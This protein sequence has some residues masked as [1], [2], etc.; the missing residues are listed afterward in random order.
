M[1]DDLC[2]GPFAEPLVEASILAGLVRHGASVFYEVN[3][4]LRPESFADADNQ[5]IYK[6]LAAALSSGQADSVDR[7]TLYVAAAS[8]GFADYLERPEIKR[9]IE[10]L[11]RIPVEAD[12][13]EKLCV[14]LKIIETSR[15][16]RARFRLADENL[17]RVT[18]DESIDE[19]F[20]LAEEP[21][22]SVML[23][24]AGGVKFARTRQ[25]AEGARERFRERIRNPVA[26]VGIP[27][28][29]SRFDRAHGGCRP[30]SVT[31]I[32]ARMKTGKTMFVNNVAINVA[33]QLGV[34]VLNIDTEMDIEQQMD[35][36]AACLSGL[37]TDDLERGSLNKEQQRRLGAAL[38]RL[39][40]M[41]YFYEEVRDLP[42]DAILS[43]IKRWV[44]KYVGFQP[45]GKANPC[46]VVFD[47]FKLMTEG[48]AQGRL[49]IHHKMGFQAQALKNLMAEL[50]TPC[51]CFAQANRDGID[52]TDE[53]I[54]RDADR[55]LD[56]VT[57]FWVFRRKPDAEIMPARKGELR[58]THEL[59]FCL[60]RFGKGLDRANYINIGTDYSRG[61]MA[62][63][64]TR[65]EL[66]QQQ[67]GLLKGVS[68]DAAPVAPAAESA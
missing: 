47:Y 17:S 52:F 9:Y 34:P 43:R 54:L 55:I 56:T 67:G 1:T 21:V 40:K 59:Y 51:V 66:F 45:N 39:E 63:G 37:W 10:S 53:R 50:G 62:E 19:L 38:D 31:L 23:E 8:L 22:Q 42:F 26:A 24:L 3:L 4:L 65:D 64:P 32:C 30:G 12:S 44:H 36:A 20:R 41:P 27:T 60:S 7:P 6:C 28:G 46:L 11:Y 29:F 57:S 48:E 35:R 25:I 13:V 5:L 16:L 14:R 61:L 2:A 49:A 68:D 18:G 33:E 58:L 15:D